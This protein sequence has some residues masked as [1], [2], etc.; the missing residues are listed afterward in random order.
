MVKKEYE[1]LYRVSHKKK[2]GPPPCEHEDIYYE[3]GRKRFVCCEC[4][5]IIAE[6]P[7]APWAY[8]CSDTPGLFKK[9]S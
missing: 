6:G 7:T 4:R 1:V 8:A 2:P 9:R 5:K 3:S